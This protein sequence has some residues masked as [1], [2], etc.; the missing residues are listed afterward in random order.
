MQK[1]NALLGY[2]QFR[3]LLYPC[4]IFLGVWV[5][6]STVYATKLPVTEQSYR[7][8]RD[9]KQSDQQLTADGQLPS[10]PAVVIHK[11]PLSIL[12]LT[13]T[14]LDSASK[15]L[16]THNNPAKTVSYLKH[17]G[18]EPETIGVIL[19]YVDA[20]YIECSIQLQSLMKSMM[21]QH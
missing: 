9:V 4:L 2:R 10:F 17:Y 8:V 12:A 18:I 11:R 15:Q 7:I 3:I 1:I 20:G 13:Q 16:D 5:L 21:T 6:S 14:V 19:Y